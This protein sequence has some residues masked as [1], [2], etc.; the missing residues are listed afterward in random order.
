M[1]TM[2]ERTSGSAPSKF[3]GLKNVR[4]G[5]LCK[6]GHDHTGDG[7]SYRHVDNATCVQCQRERIDRWGKSA[8]GR[9][10]LRRRKQRHKAKAAETARLYRAKNRERI[11]GY[12][13]RYHSENR[14]WFLSYYR[15]YNNR[16]K[17]AIIRATPDW[18]DADAIA[19][20]YRAAA[21]MGAQYHVDHIVPLRSKIVCGLHVE[22]NLRVIPGREN[23][24]KGNRSWP[25]MP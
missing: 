23:T 20:V 8:E 14:H 15:D 11:A 22:S 21:A 4:L 25:D 16:R 3:S 19:L 10:S 5:R 24:S 17:A 2:I 7:R 9:A 1:D 12:N 6:H 18:A 13:R